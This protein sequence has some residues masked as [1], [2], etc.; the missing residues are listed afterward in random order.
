MELLAWAEQT[1]ASRYRR[2][3]LRSLVNA[4]TTWKFHLLNTDAGTLSSELSGQY[5]ELTE[6]NGV[7]LT[8]EFSLKF[9]CLYVVSLFD[10][11]MFSVNPDRP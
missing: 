6:G 9:L 3:L 8:S 7:A 10:N 11:A 2:E 5:L 1:N 4:R